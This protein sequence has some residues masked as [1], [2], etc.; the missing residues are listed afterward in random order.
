MAST[1]K[2]IDR[3]GAGFEQL[4][5]VCGKSDQWWVGLIRDGSR[6]SLGPAAMLLWKAGER[7]REEARDWFAELPSLAQAEERER[8][9]KNE[10]TLLGRM[11][12]REEI[13]VPRLAARPQK[14]EYSGTGAVPCFGT[15]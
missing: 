1:A 5:G 10:R 3:G 13:G 4:T 12:R 7:E 8:C 15:E 6:S 9:L 14:V 2:A 11:S